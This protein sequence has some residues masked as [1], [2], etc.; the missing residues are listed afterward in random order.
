MRRDKVQTLETLPDSAAA[1]RIVAAARHH[2]FTHGFRGV[3]MDDLAAELGMSKKTLYACF[4]SKIALLE[5]VL[6]AKF[7]GIEEEMENIT[8]GTSAD[9]IAGLH[10]LLACVQRQTEEIRPPFLRDI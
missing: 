10:E 7:R 6:L 9:F 1:V 8:S 5:A 4:P 2:F 3:T